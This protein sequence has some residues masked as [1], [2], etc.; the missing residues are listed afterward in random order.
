MILFMN[1]GDLPGSAIPVMNIAVDMLKKL[2]EMSIEL[3]VD[4]IK[5]IL[6]G[7]IKAMDLKIND[8][9]SKIQKI[10]MDIHNMKSGIE[11]DKE[12]LRALK[13]SIGK[14]TTTSAKKGGD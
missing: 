4:G 6:V 8:I 14:N 13:Q 7:L 5:S 1:V 9:D 12:T 11:T 2:A 3:G 10:D